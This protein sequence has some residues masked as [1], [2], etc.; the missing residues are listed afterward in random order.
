MVYE[1]LHP[2]IVLEDSLRIP[3]RR[4]AQDLPSCGSGARQSRIRGN[5]E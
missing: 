2:R 5:P 3:G 4:K 1:V